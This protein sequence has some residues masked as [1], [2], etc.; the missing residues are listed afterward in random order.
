MSQMK[1]IQASARP[2]LMAT[3]VRIGQQS[4]VPAKTNKAESAPPTRTAIVSTVVP[5][6]ILLDG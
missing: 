4:R 2:T 3:K 5:A 6:L 1:Q